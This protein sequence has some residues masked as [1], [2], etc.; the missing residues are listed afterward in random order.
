MIYEMQTFRQLTAPGYFD[1]SAQQLPKTAAMAAWFDGVAGIWEDQINLFD[2]TFRLWASRDYSAVTVAMPAYLVYLLNGSEIGWF[3]GTPAQAA[4]I[5]GYVSKS[6]PTSTALAL[7]QLFTFLLNPPLGWITGPGQIFFASN[8]PARFAETLIIYSDAGAPPSTPAPQ[9]YT[10]LTWDA[11]ATWSK[12]AL[13]STY[14]ARGY[15]SA[16]NIVWMTPR[17]TASVSIMSDVA[18]LGSL[19]GS[20]TTG[21]LCGVFDDG[22]GDQGAVYYYDGAVWRKTTTP[23]ANQGLVSG[24]VAPQPGSS[25]FAPSD[26]GFISSATQPP[27]SGPS[28]GYGYYGVY[29]NFEQKAKRIDILLDLTADGAANLGMIV[30]LLR[31]L[32]PSLNALFLNYTTP[33]E[34]VS[35][36]LQVFDSGAVS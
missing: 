16:G 12:I 1:F 19:P 28:Q 20:P 32:K 25:V 26:T 21:D 13:N 10:A 29:G 33:T 7:Q 4:A 31:L 30:F 3:H 14:Y 8:Q 11:P 9:A 27:V 5:L 34:P 18:D 15:L 23:N 36:E 22:T 2:D 6:Y 24:G 35:I 17:S